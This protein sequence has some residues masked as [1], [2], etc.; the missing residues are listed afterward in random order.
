[1]KAKHGKDLAFF[2]LGK[3]YVGTAL[4]EA[5]WCSPFFGMKTALRTAESK[6]SSIM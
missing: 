5:S 1:M 6:L 2:V 4:A 3:A